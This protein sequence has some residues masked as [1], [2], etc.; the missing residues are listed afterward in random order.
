MGVPFDDEV[1]TGS[2]TSST[3]GAGGAIP[4]DTSTGSITSIVGFAV[5]M[6]FGALILM[7]I[8]A[9]Q[10]KEKMPLPL[11]RRLAFGHLAALVFYETQLSLQSVVSHHP[12]PAESGQTLFAQFSMWI[13][14]LNVAY[15]GL[16]TSSPPRLTRILHGPSFGSAHALLVTYL[17]TFD[18]SNRIASQLNPADASQTLLLAKTA[19]LRVAPF[20]LHWIDGILGFK[21]LSS[22][23][24]FS[25]G[26]TG[27]G[28]RGVLTTAAIYAALRATLKMWAAAVGYS[29]LYFAWALRYDPGIW[30]RVS[31]RPTSIQPFSGPLLATMPEVIGLASSIL[32][33]CIFTQR[34][35]GMPAPPD[36]GNLAAFQKRKH[37]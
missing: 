28:D 11:F 32:A 14:V 22:C 8:M 29:A 30:S 17:W 26:S 2:S 20:F 25:M 23:Y 7:L 34:L 13:L 10:G 27:S 35:F 5:V 16:C 33:F 12:P 36:E 3:A 15:F 18:A 31:K 37:E 9:A 1:F 6:S 24:S 19:W 4:G 21:E